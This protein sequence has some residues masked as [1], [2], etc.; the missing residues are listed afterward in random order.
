VNLRLI[1]KIN[2]S[3]VI[4]GKTF[5]ALAKAERE[6]EKSK[7]DT[8]VESYEKQ[9]LIPPKEATPLVLPD[10]WHGLQNKLISRYLQRPIRTLLVTGTSH[11][12]GVTSTVVKFAQTLAKAS[13]RKVLIVDANFRSPG[14][15]LRFDISPRD[16]LSDLLVNNGL[17]IFNFKKT[18]QEGLYL[19]TCGRKYPVGKCK[20]ESERFD[21]F[22]NIAQ[23]RFDYTILDSAPIT[24]FAESQAICSRVDGVLLVIETGKTRRQVAIRAKKELE[25]AGG[26]L[27]GVVM[28]KRKYHIPE[29]IYRR[30]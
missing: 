20:F 24:S 15:H 14:M 19:F 3:G 1:K 4:M 5:E 17:H 28:N 16:G 23:Q 26:R 11:G 29:W 21:K 25:E 13:D 22:M 6:F 30:L 12:A 9:W 7:Y 10:G 27:L 2:K 8:A 18:A